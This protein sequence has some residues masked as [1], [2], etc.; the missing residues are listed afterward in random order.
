MS[1][2][3]TGNS[4]SITL[5]DIQGQIAKLNEMLNAYAEEEKK[6]PR[7]SDANEKVIATFKDPIKLNVGGQIFMARKQ[8]IHS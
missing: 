3:S 2:T 6:H 8:I 5:K 4:K 7:G 1:V